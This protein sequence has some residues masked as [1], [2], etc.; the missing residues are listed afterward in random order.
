MRCAVCGSGRLSP[1]GELTSAEKWNER[2]RHKFT[3]PGILKPRPTFN[4]GFARAC[5]DCGALIAFLGE[6]GRRQL[7]AVADGLTGVAGGHSVGT[8]DQDR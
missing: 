2:L 3:R 1:V 4:V 5:R 8:A 6:Y 7:D